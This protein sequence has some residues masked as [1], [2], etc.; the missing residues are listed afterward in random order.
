MVILHLN[1]EIITKLKKKILVTGIG[2]HSRSCL[3]IIENTKQYEIA[4]YVEKNKNSIKYL[5]DLK[6][7]GVDDD[8]PEIFKK[9]K[10]AHIAI[11]HIKNIRLRKNLYEKLNKIGFKFPKIISKKS[12]ISEK[13]VSI[14]KGTIIMNNVT[15]NSHCFIGDN[16]IINTGSIIEHDCHIGSHSLIGPG[17]IIN[18]GAKLGEEIFLGSG[19]VVRN[20]AKLKSKSFF[21]MMSKIK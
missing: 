10:Y 21:P 2:G 20:G 4:G 8:L 15:I 19:S 7:L 18:G 6:F 3:D 17:S 12:I 11:G 16:C 13:K 14:G 1:T 5:T 9:I